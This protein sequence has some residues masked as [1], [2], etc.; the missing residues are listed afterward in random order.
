VPL[1]VVHR[2]VKS[3]NVFV[4][5][6]GAVKIGD[7]GIAKAVGQA[8]AVRTE[9]GEVK[10]TAAY[11][12]PE[13]RSGHDVDRRA[14]IY[15][16]GALCYELLTGRVINLDYAMLAHLGRAGWPHL[17]APSALRPELPPELDRIVLRAMAF[18]PAARFP[19]CEALELALANVVERHGLGASDK[20]IA[21]WI[22][23]EL[24]LLTIGRAPGGAQAGGWPGAA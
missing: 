17:A 5:R 7:F 18:E 8:R 24:A 16:V 10:G 6:T 12:S 20:M 1:Q 2:D 19:T 3:A 14:D 13:Q 22:E 21:R 15:G 23:V 4:A 9:L 11:M